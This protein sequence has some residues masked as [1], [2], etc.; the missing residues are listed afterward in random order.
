M[1]SM[2]CGQRD[3]TLFDL[4]PAQLFSHSLSSGAVPE[5]LFH[6]SIQEHGVQS[7]MISS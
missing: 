3:P 6:H 1:Q 5:R 2:V 4:Q 7:E